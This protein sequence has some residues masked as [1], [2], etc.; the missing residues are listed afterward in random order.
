MIVQNCKYIRSHA[1]D[2][3]NYVVVGQ[4]SVQSSATY[5]FKPYKIHSVVHTDGIKASTSGCYGITKVSNKILIERISLF[6]IL[7][8]GNIFK[9]T[10]L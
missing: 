2:V 9:Y 1:P 7:F 8:D 5:Q 6:E 3:D 10:Y 4:Y